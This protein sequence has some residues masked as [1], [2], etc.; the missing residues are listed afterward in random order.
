MSSCSK[1][2]L[3]FIFPAYVWFILLLIII[4]SQ[5]SSKVV[6]LVGRQAIPVLATMILLSYFKLIRTV[7][8][9]LYFMQIPC[10]NGKNN[11]VTLLRWYIN[12]NVQY[13]RGCHL[14]LFL[15]S[16]VVFILLAPK[17]LDVLL[18][19]LIA[20]IFLYRAFLGNI[21]AFSF[22]LSGRFFYS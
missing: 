4:L 11:T 16:L 7:F 14:P 15:F 1:A 19:F 6:C 3:Q 21:S 18:S 22:G 12:P 8:K 20:I 2:W 5:Y 10:T 13:A 9:A 17:C